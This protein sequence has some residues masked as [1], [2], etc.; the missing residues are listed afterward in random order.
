MECVVRVVA[1]AEDRKRLLE[2]GF[3]AMPVYSSQPLEDISR[4]IYRTM[5]DAADL[6]SLVLSEPVMEAGYED[7][8][9]GRIVTVSAAVFDALAVTG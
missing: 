2:H 8:W 3:M 7:C 4:D 9:G 5:T 1:Y 6:M